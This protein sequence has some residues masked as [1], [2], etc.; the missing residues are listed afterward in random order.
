MDWP[1]QTGGR[2]VPATHQANH[3]LMARAGRESKSP[4]RE[5]CC[6]AWKYKPRRVLLSVD[7]ITEAVES[8]L[9][10]EG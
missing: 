3:F 6:A 5:L 10:F 4:V 9:P 8:L 7:T 1:M 2:S